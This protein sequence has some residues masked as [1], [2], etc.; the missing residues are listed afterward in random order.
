MSN[1]LSRL[2]DQD[3]T[4]V[5][6][7]KR[8]KEIFKQHKN[9][10]YHKQLSV[11]QNEAAIAYNYKDWFDLYHAVKKKIENNTV[12]SSLEAL[13]IEE[14]IIQADNLLDQI[15]LDSFKNNYSNII[16]EHREQKTTV[17]VRINGELTAYYNPLFSEKDYQQLNQDT[18]NKLV[19][20]SIIKLD[21]YQCQMFAGEYNV[22]G[23]K[24][25]IRGQT[26]PCYPYGQDL[27]LTLYKVDNLTNLLALGYSADQEQVL[28]Q[29]VQKQSGALFFAGIT[30]AGKSTSVATLLKEIN[31]NNSKKVYSIEHPIEKTIPHVTQIPI[32]IP[33][34][35]DYQYDLYDQPI[36]SCLRTCPDILLVNPM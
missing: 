20:S 5:A 25:K 3:K 28:H 12:N 29:L 26:V 32:V 30:G 13:S 21:M 10:Q 23:K 4:I 36:T 1:N 22:N 24:I 14:S 33:Q 8:A 16:I 17:R 9:T 27:V 7:K 2:I 6:C 31:K 19:N 18:F 11:C 15:L 34:E 35:Y